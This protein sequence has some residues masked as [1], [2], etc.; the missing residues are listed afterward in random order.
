MY[1]LDSDNRAGALP[2]VMES[3]LA[4]NAG[5]Q[6]SY[7]LDVYTV[8]LQQV[9]R[10][11]F[12]EFVEGFPVFNGTGA[13]VI[14][15]QSMS[16]RWGAVICTS[17]AHINT[18]ECG[19][20]ERVAGIKLLSVDSPDGKLTPDLIDKRAHG[21]NVEHFAQPCVV[22]IT[23]ST[24]LGTVYSVDEI[25]DICDHAHSLEMSVHMDGARL[26]NAAASLGVS[27]REL[28]TD[29]GVDVVS[30]GGT[31]CGL[32]FGEVIVVLNQ[33]TCQG[34]N[35][36]RKYN[37]QLASK[38]RFISAQFVALLEGSLWLEAATRANSRATLLRERIDCL[39]TVTV[40]QPT[41]AN[42]VF[43]ILP[44]G[45]EEELRKFA[46]FQTWNPEVSE[47]RLMC[48]H[49]TSIGDVNGFVDALER[50]LLEGQ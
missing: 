47:V 38:M 14:A 5:H 2:E 19:A 9:L 37:M 41:Q 6:A 28:T 36:I 26:S 44:I 18:A 34:V 17:D 11:H 15:L 39:P 22:S 49:D 30:F 48:S 29:V 27:L 35:Y 1:S 16:P 8:R 12:G 31:K 24:E 40:T 25:R 43:A 33:N 32:L 50:I 13:N 21:F 20:P 42:A 23:Q 45:V 4:A 46:E 3:V 10:S 7:G